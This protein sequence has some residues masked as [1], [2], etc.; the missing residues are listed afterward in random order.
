MT[1][2]DRKTIDGFQVFVL[3]SEKLRIIV[4][5]EPGAKV[6]SILNSRTDSE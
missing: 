5:P 4:V 1:K 3:I 2:V 6:I